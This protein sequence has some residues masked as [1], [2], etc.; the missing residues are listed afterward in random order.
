MTY[1]LE[2]RLRLIDFLLASY[3]FV[4]PRQLVDFFSIS[5]PQ[6]SLDFA[7]YNK[8]YPGNMVYAH[9]VLNWQA[10]AAFKRAYP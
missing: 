5:K 3:G 1:A 4:A 7:M 8:T 6:A 2:Q 10:T 9:S